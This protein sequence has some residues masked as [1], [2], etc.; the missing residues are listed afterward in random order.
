MIHTFSRKDFTSKAFDQM[1]NSILQVHK[2]AYKL[3]HFSDFMIDES[4]KVKLHQYR[5]DLLAIYTR[6]IE[7]VRP[8]YVYIKNTSY[9][10]SGYSREFSSQ[11]YLLEDFVKNKTEQTRQKIIKGF[12]SILQTSYETYWEYMNAKTPF[13]QAIEAFEKQYNNVN[14]HTKLLD[15]VE[16]ESR[17][18][19]DD[20]DLLYPSIEESLL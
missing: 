4:T 13:I 17:D 8:L 11:D 19:T 2:I 1:D 16:Y 18:L 9:D 3:H 6:L 20:F 10:T 14:T 15:L 12:L 7:I 5:Q